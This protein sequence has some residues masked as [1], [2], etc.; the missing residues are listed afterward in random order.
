MKFLI[1]GNKVE[2]TTV[3]FND[4]EKAFY[5][6]DDDKQSSIRF[7]YR[8][9]LDK[10]FNSKNFSI[11]FLSNPYLKAEINHFPVSIK[12]KEDGTKLKIGWI[13]PIQ[14]LNSNDVSSEFLDK[15]KFKIFHNLLKNN[16]D[17]FIYNE[18]LNGQS[19]YQITDIYDEDIIILVVDNEVFPDT[20][21]FSLL[22]FLPSLAGYGYQKWI[23]GSGRFLHSEIK[24]VVSISMNGKTTISIKKCHINI[25]EIPFLVALYEEHLPSIHHFFIR[26]HYLYQVIEC[27][28]EPHRKK[29][30]DETIE[31]FQKAEITAN[32]FREHLQ[33]ELKE[34]PLIRQLFANIKNLP[35]KN[36][37]LYVR[38]FFDKAGFEYEDKCTAELIYNTRNKLVHNYGA[39]SHNKDA[40]IIFES[41][42]NCFE[43]IIHHLI[44]HYMP[45]KEPI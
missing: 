26:F 7:P 35:D 20:S 22:D 4:D 23:K 17:E 11:F 14:V 18:K 24:E 19:E 42:T 33:Q 30:V 31:K 15:I 21:D 12:C 36:F 34:R 1:E 40:L 2:L 16:G 13:F 43:L 10:D 44:V 5:L 37:K 41:A 29:I 27:L 32:D 8:P 3:D 38:D 28:F 9:N 45:E 39:V 6:Y 25:S